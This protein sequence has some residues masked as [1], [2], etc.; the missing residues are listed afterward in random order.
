MLSN[1][2]NVQR[3]SEELK[4]LSSACDCG[5]GCTPVAIKPQ[6]DC[7]CGCTTANMRSPMGRLSDREAGR[8]A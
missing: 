4:V 8:T 2:E 3:E 7:G 6:C 1:P 5:C